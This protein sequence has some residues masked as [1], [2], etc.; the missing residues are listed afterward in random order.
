[1]AWIYLFTDNNNY[2][3]PI[4]EIVQLEAIENQ[5]QVPYIPLIDRVRDDAPL[6]NAG[7]GVLVYLCTRN[8]GQWSIHGDALIAHDCGLQPMTPQSV[9][10]L[11]GILHNR[12]WKALANINLYPQ[13]QT[14]AQI[15]IIRPLPMGGQAAA[16]NLDPG[17]IAPGGAAIPAP[18]L[19]LLPRQPRLCNGIVGRRFVG[20]DLTAGSWVS[21]LDAG[22]RA[23]PVLELIGNADGTLSL[24]R[25]EM[26]ATLQQFQQLGWAMSADRLIIDGPCK[27]N[28][29]ALLN[30]PTNWNFSVVSPGFR[31]AEQQL[32]QMGVGL[33]WTTL[34]T[35]RGFDG[36]SRWIA[37]SV[38]LFSQLLANP[39]LTNRCIETHPHAVFVIM[40]RALAGGLLPKKKTLPGRNQRLALLRGFV[41]G[42]QENLLP[43][44]DH[45][46]AAAA[47]LLGAL[48][49]SNCALALGNAN[50]GGQIWIPDQ[51]A[52]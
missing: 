2:P 6:K 39:A 42:L 22:G 38:Q 24:G 28:G 12:R 50:N 52:L 18:N 8:N 41:P 44:H 37:R 10:G 36:A 33:F 15:G 11:Y 14:P 48:Q 35:L 47:A 13:P 43:T 25:I 26:C 40:A 32:A 46:D 51:T 4:Q 17:Q 16:I 27:T 20:V 34:A 9:R 29:I 30:P 49:F 7:A 5:G 31:V 45:V 1:M 23:F 19:A 21:Q 3:H